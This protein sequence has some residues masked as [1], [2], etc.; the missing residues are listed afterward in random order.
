MIQEESLL[1][2]SWITEK[3][4]Y[5]SPNHIV[6]CQNVILG[7]LIEKEMHIKIN[8]V[9]LYAKYFIYIKKKSNATHIN[10]NEFINFA[11]GKIDVHLD[12]AY[13]KNKAQF[14]EEMCTLRLAMS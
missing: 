1:L 5:H 9:T 7:Y 3:S 4:N 11:K 14:I 6:T 2:K 13:R 12:V 10:F 8:F